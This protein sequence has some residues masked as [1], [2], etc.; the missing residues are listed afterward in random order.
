MDRVGDGAARGKL[1]LKDRQQAAQ[2][3]ADRLFA[4]EN[5]IDAAVRSAAEL[6]AAMPEA[7]TDARLSAVIGQEALDQ[8]AEAFAL[9]VQ[10]RRAMVA[11]HHKLEETR[12]RIGLREVNVGDSLPK[13]EI[14]RNRNTHVRA[15]A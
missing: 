1:M 11:T 5:A 4:V 9:L 2:K 7:R 14:A 6:T 8:A 13:D 3:V 15:V 10:A 12:I